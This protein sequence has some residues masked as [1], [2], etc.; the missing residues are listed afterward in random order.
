MFLL[1]GLYFAASI[2]R[3]EGR[4]ALPDMDPESFGIDAVIE[5]RLREEQQVY[6]NF[7][8]F[9]DLY[10]RVRIDTI[11]SVKKQPEL[12]KSR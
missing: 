2:M 12:F 10:K 5:Q 6:E 11:Q 8:A 7:M 4:E 1:S 3:E 9:P